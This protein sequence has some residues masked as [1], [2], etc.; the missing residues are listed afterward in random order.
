[1]KKLLKTK[2]LEV[3]T[4]TVRTLTNKQLEHVAGGY[5]VVNPSNA[6]TAKCNVTYVG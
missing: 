1:M 6:E 2:K 3:K 4:E 5:S